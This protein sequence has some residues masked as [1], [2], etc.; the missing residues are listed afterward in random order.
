MFFAA[1][2]TSGRFRLTTEVSQE[3]IIGAAGTENAAYLLYPYSRMIHHG[4]RIK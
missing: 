1:L 3:K 2:P 4:I